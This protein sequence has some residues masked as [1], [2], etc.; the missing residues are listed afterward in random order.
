[1]ATLAIG[2]KQT[3]VVTS[4]TDLNARSVTAG[5]VGGITLD[6]GTL[7]V[8][9]TA[10]KLRFREGSAVTYTSGTITGATGTGSIVIDDVGA[11]IALLG[12][13]AFV[14]A[15]GAAL[16]GIGAN[17]PVAANTTKVVSEA[18][19]SGTSTEIS[20]ALGSKAVVFYTNAAG[21]TATN[22]GT[23]IGDGKTLVVTS[24]AATVTLSGATL[25]LTGGSA[26]A[27]LQT[28]GDIVV[29]STNPIT[30][31]G[32]VSIVTGAAAA[33][34]ALNGTA[35]TVILT[36]NSAQ[37]VLSVGGT[38][39]IGVGLKIVPANGTPATLAT[40][41][42][43]DV[44][45]LTG[46]AAGSSKIGTAAGD[47]LILSGGS[48]VASNT[49]ETAITTFGPGSYVTA[50]DATATLLLSS[51]VIDPAGGA[52]T[53]SAGAKITTK[54]ATTLTPANLA[55]VAGAATT[56]AG[57]AD[58]VYTS[59]AALAS[60][61]LNG[62]VGKVLF[63]AGASA[64][65]ITAITTDGIFTFGASA[66][67]PA[68]TALVVNST[69]M[70]TLVIG[71][72][73]T[74]FTPAQT[75][76]ITG[77]K[78]TL[79]L[80]GGLFVGGTS[81]KATTF[82]AAATYS[83]AA[84]TIDVGNDAVTFVATGILTLSKGAVLKAYATATDEEPV[85]LTAGA[86]AGTDDVVI[87][88]AVAGIVTLDAGV[89]TLVGNASN[90]ATL[91]AKGAGTI[92]VGGATNSVTFTGALFTAATGG[93]ANSDTTLTGA[94]GIVDIAVAQG[95]AN[96]GKLALADGGAIVT[97]GTGHVLVS[98]GLKIGGVAT[99]VTA[100]DSDSHTI[101]IVF[102]STNTTATLT[103]NLGGSG[104]ANDG[105]VIGTD[106]TQAN[107]FKLL[108]L[109]TAAA[110]YTFTAAADNDAP[111]VISGTGIVVP[112]DT[113]GGSNTGAILT[114]DAK[115]NIVLGNGS[116]TLG[117]ISSTST[118]GAGKLV[119]AENGKMGVF[120]DTTHY[121]LSA[122]QNFKGGSEGEAATVV[123]GGSNSDGTLVLASINV[124]GAKG[125]GTAVDG[126]ISKSSSME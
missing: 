68:N 122:S 121:T 27:T 89:F 32:P 116:I 18:P 118:S 61:D 23:A 70:A 103:A 51:G 63:E 7:S 58:V 94:G 108:A 119:L 39:T 84:K 4:Y 98:T 73:N 92:V 56:T 10:G 43:G 109:D 95:A 5:S 62:F 41:A 91:E 36:G 21:L 50:N 120:T 49:G 110:V 30:L 6:G 76:A 60:P 74:P 75:L 115:S 1:V 88:N 113:L 40:K 35:G 34:V 48:I 105:I 97:A 28:A 124:Y 99:T 114:L 22:I 117:G 86:T 71:A 79:D 102:A 106:S 31:A 57:N 93:S 80:G 53:L 25:T 20:T 17:P 59:A 69:T 14:T 9:A 67:L 46:G 77:N 87:T 33:T 45:T 29:G 65:A 15:A 112:A 83:T 3:L 8:S 123:I 82:P 52:L 107:N 64:V 16:I 111:V 100:I 19:E 72:D 12:N 13:D 90:A 81:N 54:D 125:T 78:A 38:S 2:E 47:F 24:P 126:V 55:Y 104:D 42:T 44:I 11:A 66:T 85:I 101:P 26:A 37:P 96:G